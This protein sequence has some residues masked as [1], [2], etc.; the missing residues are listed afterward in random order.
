MKYVIYAV[1]DCPYC[2]KIYNYMIDHGMSFAYIVIHNMDKDLQE[3][4]DKFNWYTV[5]MVFEEGDD[6]EGEKF[7]GG[8]DDT[9][10][11]FE[12][13]RNHGHTQ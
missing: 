12:R 11:Y 5:P 9:I 13:R 8:A 2:D 6:N 1:K 7:L 10:K 3:M 4:K